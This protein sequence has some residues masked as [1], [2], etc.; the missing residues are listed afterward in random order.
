MSLWVKMRVKI[1]SVALIL[2]LS[3]CGFAPLHGTNSTT[4]NPAIETGFNQ[5][6]IENIPDQEGQYLRN[7]LIDRLYNSGRPNNARYR[8]KIETIAE[9]HTNL[10]V[11]KS[12]DATRAQMRLNTAMTLSDR[13]TGAALLNRKLISITSYNVLQSHFTTKVSEDNARR[14]A[15]DDLA[16][17]IELQL[18]LYFKRK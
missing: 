9:K 13:T 6:F 17:Q 10:D 8:L 15:L 12:S 11:T 3:A 7:A 2:T 14:N 1:L 16:R 5:V 4:Q 18:S